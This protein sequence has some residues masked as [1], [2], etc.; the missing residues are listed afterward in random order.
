MTPQLRFFI[1]G[2]LTAGYLVAALFFLRFWRE[3]GD[4]LFGYFAASFSLL[5][6]QRAVLA[7]V[8]GED[9]HTAWMYL[10][11]LLAYALILVA[12][13]GKNR[14]ERRKAG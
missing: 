9:D 14:T 8:R 13:Y 12:I 2:M 7:L 1:E 3:S 5:A 6:V 10:I 11:R 4:R